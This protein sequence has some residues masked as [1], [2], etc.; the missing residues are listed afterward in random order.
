MQNKNLQGTAIIIGAGPAGLTAALELLERTGIVPVVIEM[1]DAIGGI[2]RTIEHNGNRMDIGGHRFFSKS[3]RVMNWWKEKLPMEEREGSSVKAWLIR[4]RLSRILY[5][6]KFFDYPVSLSGKT[7]KNLGIIKIIKI[8]FSYIYIRLFPIKDEK[9]LE[10]F[11]T[12][13]FGRELYRTFFKDYTEKVWGV[14]CSGISADWG[15]QR[16]KGLSV[17]KTIIHAL[18]KIFSFKKNTNSKKVETSLIERFLY[19]KFGPGQLWEEVAERVIKLG[20][21]IYMEQKVT[22]IIVENGKVK[23]VEATAADGTVNRFEGDWVFSTMPV[24]ELISG[25]GD[26]V[27]E[28][29]SEVAGGLM[30][31]DFITVG[32]LLKKMRIVDPSNPNMPVK[33]NWIYIQEPDVKVGRLQL[34]HNWSPWMVKDK[35]NCFVG[36]EYFCNEGDELWSMT[37]SDFIQFAVSELI[38]IGVADKADVIETNVFKMLKA[39]PAYFGTYDKFELV[40][41]FTDSIENLYLIGRNGMHRYNNSDHSMLTAMVAVDNLLSGKADKSNIWAVNTEA[42]YHEEKQAEKVLEKKEGRE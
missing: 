21:R 36:M 18:R 41:E 15:S 2:S 27:P 20:G 1:T 9:S 14:P 40:R 29:V 6:R 23:A 16:V 7:I 34:F 33:D 3:E 24:C 12:N 17:S 22:K 13:R 35:N 30:Y 39:Y 32:V 4:N 11:F 42:E 8:G 26:V 37:D 38:K 28:R 10:D 31:R 25:M 19:P 5:S